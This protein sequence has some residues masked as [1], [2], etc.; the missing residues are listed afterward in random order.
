[1]EGTASAKPRI[2]YHSRERF[3]LP[4]RTLLIAASM[5]IP[6]TMIP[7][8]RLVSDM[9][10]TLVCCVV[11]LPNVNVDSG[12]K[13]LEV[14]RFVRGWFVP[15][16]FWLPIQIKLNQGYSIQDIQYNWPLFLQLGVVFSLLF[17]CLHLCGWVLIDMYKFNLNE[18]NPKKNGG[19][20][21]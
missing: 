20:N 15:V 16:G 8:I 18:S 21:S 6:K 4:L 1:M 17:L 3:T 5:I 11:Y 12:L 10:F 7:I 9:M 13:A 2:R 14:P 19:K